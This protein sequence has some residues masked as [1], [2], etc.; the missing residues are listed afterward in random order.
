MSRSNGVMLL[1]P[2]SS[3]RNYVTPGQAE[4]GHN[5]GMVCLSEWKTFF[6]W[7][8]E[9]GE[10]EKYLVKAEEVAAEM[11]AKFDGR[12]EAVFKAL[13]SNRSGELAMAEME[14]TF[15]EETHDYWAN[16][17]GEACV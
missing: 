7:C 13:D 15:G 17:D 3:Q 10:G 14:A 2:N 12:V 11:Q 8:T 1:S 6:D 16:I 5:D 9:K 4:E